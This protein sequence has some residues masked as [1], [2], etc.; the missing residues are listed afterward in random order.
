MKSVSFPV[1]CVC[2]YVEEGDMA[3]CD[4][5]LEWFHESCVPVPPEV[6]SVT[7]RIV[8]NHCA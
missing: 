5:C 2:R 4:T 8:Q 7:V 6:L 1:Y 3:R